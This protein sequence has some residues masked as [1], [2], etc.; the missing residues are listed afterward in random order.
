MWYKQIFAQA[1]ARLKSE[2]VRCRGHW[3]YPAACGDAFVPRAPA[4][5][6]LTFR[7]LGCYYYN[8]FV[9]V[10]AVGSLPVRIGAQFPRY[11]KNGNTHQM[12]YVFWKGSS[13]T[14][15][16]RLKSASCQKAYRGK[17]R[18]DSTLSLDMRPSTFSEIIG[19]KISSRPSRTSWGRACPAPSCWSA[20]MAAAKQ[21]GVVDCK[22]HPRLGFQRPAA[23]AGNQRRELPQDYRHPQTGQGCGAYPMVGKYGVI[24]M[25]GAAAYQTRT[26]DFAQGIGGARIAHRVDYL[27]SSRKRLTVG[28]IAAISLLACGESRAEKRA[29][30][31]ARA[32]AQLRHTGDTARLRGGCNQGQ[33]DKPAQNPASISAVPQRYFG[34]GRCQFHAVCGSPGILRDLHGRSIRPVG[35]GLHPAVDCGKGNRQAGSRS[36]LWPGSLRR[37]AIS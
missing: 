8:R 22:V 17:I 19:R 16:Y 13:A 25:A 32:A 20:H 10:T 29:V 28:C 35:Q 14:S 3:R 21:A 9:L 18:M 33:A 27:H 2:Q 5:T 37:C 1:V 30:L 6:I 15:R 7:R 31:I 4:R 36:S 23:G 11:R 24:I 34:A 12:I 26:A